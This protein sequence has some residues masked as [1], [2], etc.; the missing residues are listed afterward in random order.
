MD[1]IETAIRGAAEEQARRIAKIR[2][3][4]SKHSRR[5]KVRLIADKRHQG[6]KKSL[7]A[8]VRP[9]LYDD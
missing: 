6:E 3:Q 1:K 7:R 2:R 4:K 9:D 5:A 8:A